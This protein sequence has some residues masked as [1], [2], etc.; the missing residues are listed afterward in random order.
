MSAVLSP[1]STIS[2]VVPWWKVCHRVTAPPTICW[3]DETNIKKR[4]SGL[5]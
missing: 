2:A 1:F 4:Y 3:G 5:A